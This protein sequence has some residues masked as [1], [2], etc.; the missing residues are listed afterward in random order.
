MKKV[1]FT[2]GLIAVSVGVFAQDNVAGAAVGKAKERASYS[3]D[4]LMIQLSYDGWAQAPDSLKF[5]LNRGFNIALMYDFPIK[6][7]K[8]SFAGGLGISTSSVI[9]K[10]HILD[11][12]NG[13]STAVRFERSETYRKYKVA[14]TYLEIPLEFRFRQVPENANKGFKAAIGAKVGMLVNAHTKGKNTLGGEKNII[15]E[16]NRR[17]FNPWRFA[18]TARVGY[19]NIGVFG[20]VNLNPLFKDNSGV[21]VR[22]YSIGITLSGL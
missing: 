20:A 18:A 15:K 2:L 11:M 5:G 4:F 10:D 9:L 1:L 13:S 21:D 3:R 6:A 14:T 12:S 22:P 17:F 16:Q 19:G 7:T 8:F